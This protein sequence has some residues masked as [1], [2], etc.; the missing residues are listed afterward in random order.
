MAAAAGAG[1]PVVP[2]PGPCAVVAGLVGSGLPTEEFTFAGF[3]P[4]KPLARRQ[5]LLE[6]S[7][8]WDFTSEI[9]SRVLLLGTTIIH[10]G[11]QPRSLLPFARPANTT[12][13]ET[14]NCLSKQ[15]VVEYN[16]TSTACCCM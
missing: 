3:L 5:R 4:A 14:C 10:H 6:L 1:L 13:A 15:E 2:V 16:N 7:G 12:T 8:E 9:S 11:M